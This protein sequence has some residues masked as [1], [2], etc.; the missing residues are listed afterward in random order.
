MSCTPG[1]CPTAARMQRAISHALFRNHP[2]T[3]K[4]SGCLELLGFA[5]VEGYRGD[6]DYPI[7]GDGMEQVLRRRAHG[8][9]G[10]RCP[11]DECRGSTGAIAEPERGAQGDHATMVR[12][13]RRVLA[14]HN[15]KGGEDAQVPPG[16]YGDGLHHTHPCPRCSQTY[17]CLCKRAAHLRK[18]LCPR[19]ASNPIP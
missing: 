10:A 11:T 15:E 14:T 1:L 18:A 4:C 19:C 16:S 6:Q 3:T 7:C 12:D 8:H 5:T 2:M 13:I 9:A 17:P